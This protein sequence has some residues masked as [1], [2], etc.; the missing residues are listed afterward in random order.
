[1][2]TA[3]AD[4]DR[5]LAHSAG[6]DNDCKIAHVLAKRLQAIVPLTAI[7]MVAQLLIDKEMATRA[8]FSG[9]VPD[10]LFDLRIV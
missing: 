10:V 6:D 8:D 7:R 3:E 4:A 5:A 9:I 2:Q 1:M